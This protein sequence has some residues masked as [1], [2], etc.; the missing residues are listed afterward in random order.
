MSEKKQ[1]SW[2]IYAVVAAASAIFGFGAVYWMGEGTS[3]FSNEN[4][5]T[6]SV[7]AP[8]NATSSSQATGTDMTTDLNVGAM[9]T[10]VFKDDPTPVPPAPFNNGAGQSISIENFAGRIVLLNLW[11][12]WCA[13]CRKEMPDLD[14]LQAELGGEDFEVVAVSVDRGSP[15]KSQKFLDDIDVKSLKLY[16]DPSAQLGFKLKTIGMPSTLLI[17]R[18][19]REIGRLVGPAEWD[20][21]DA[22][23]LIKAHLNHPTK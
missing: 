4:D 7:S 14:R 5:K 23:R 9:T 18:Q 1:T 6:K 3:D 16:H 15:A 11:A 13:P 10:F 12:T 20:S 8:H 21:A 22:K 17:D 19:G 2:P